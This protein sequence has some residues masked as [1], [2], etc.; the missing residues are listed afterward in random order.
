MYLIDDT[1]I[2]KIK[3]V[4]PIS[5]NVD[6]VRS[7]IPYTNETET[8]WL[9]P[10]FGYPLYKDIIDNINNYEIL[11]HGGSYNDDTEYFEGLYSAIG[12]LAYS[13]FVL[14]HNISVTQLGVLTNVD[15]QFE[16]NASESQ[17][18]R[19][20][21]DAKEIGL[22]HLAHCVDYLI[23]V[24]K[25]TECRTKVKSKSNIKVIGI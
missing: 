17:I 11:L 7:M 19:I 21:N 20:S 16:R 10:K 22:K 23:F 13:R 2:D 4:R 18:K 5:E 9:I 14:N 25:I 1:N 3:G 12:Y 6:F 15:N 8:E 24:G